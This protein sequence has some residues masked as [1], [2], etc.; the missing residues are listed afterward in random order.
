MSLLQAVFPTL[1]SLLLR[2][3]S[4]ASCVE[5]SFMLQPSRD[6]SALGKEACLTLLDIEVCPCPRRLCTYTAYTSLI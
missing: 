3:F 5:L 4:E 1:S 2:F 6:W